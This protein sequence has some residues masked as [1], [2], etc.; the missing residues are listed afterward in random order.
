MSE[1]KAEIYWKTV[2]YVMT[3]GLLEP[4]MLRLS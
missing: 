2:L 4:Y 1:N 3:L